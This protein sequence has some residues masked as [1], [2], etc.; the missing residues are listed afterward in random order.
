MQPHQL[1]VVD[2]KAELDKKLEALGVFIEQNA[3]FDGLDDAEK[4][5]LRIQRCVMESYSTILGE[6]IAAF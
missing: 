2:E 6:R 3:F 4:S 5:R 1:R